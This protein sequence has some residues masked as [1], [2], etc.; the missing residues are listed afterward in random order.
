[1]GEIIDQKIFSQSVWASVK[2]TASIDAGKVV[3][4]SPKHGTVI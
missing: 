2:G 4:E 1:M 3:Y